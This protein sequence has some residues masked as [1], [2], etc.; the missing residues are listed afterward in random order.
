L[1]IFAPSALSMPRRSPGWNWLPDSSFPRS[2]PAALPSFDEV[3]LDPVLAAGQVRGENPETQVDDV[4]AVLLKGDLLHRGVHE[5]RHSRVGRDSSREPGLAEDRAQPERRLG[6]RAVADTDARDAADREPDPQ[7][8][9]G[10]E[11]G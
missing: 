11:L 1:L 5:L 4:V 2:M 8:V 3:E 10:V 9:L 7:V 6:A